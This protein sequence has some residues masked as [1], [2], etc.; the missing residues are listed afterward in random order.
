MTPLVVD[1]SV[2]VKWF[3]PEEQSEAAR[4][5][6]GLTGYSFFAP[7]HLFAELGNVVWKKV[8][9]G[10]LD[11]RVAAALIADLARVPVETVS[12]RALLADGYSVA[13]ATGLTV[14]DG[15]YAALAVRLDTRLITADRR[16]V[17]VLKRRPG[18]G[19][20]AEWIGDCRFP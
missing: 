11:S 20:V 13:A 4:A 1:A 7:E 19:T 10:D 6:L 14:Y 3:I 8:R 16:I 15:L 17:N 9:R 5:L 12:T 2:V 18:A